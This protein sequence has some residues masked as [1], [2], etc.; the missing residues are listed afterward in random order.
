MIV[1]VR[2]LF[3]AIGHDEVTFQTSSSVAVVLE[4][5]LQDMQ[6]WGSCSGLKAI[7]ICT[8]HKCTLLLLATGMLQIAFAS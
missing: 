8:I 4:V 5:A 7:D 1:I 3:V 6:L 2:I